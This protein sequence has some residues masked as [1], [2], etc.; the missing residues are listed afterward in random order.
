MCAAHGKGSQATQT[1]PHRQH[2]HSSWLSGEEKC[3]RLFSLSAVHEFLRLSPPGFLPEP[4]STA[5]SSLEKKNVRDFLLSPSFM[6][7]C[8]FL[9]QAVSLFRQWFSLLVAMYRRRRCAQSPLFLL[10]N[11][12][13][14]YSP[15]SG[16]ATVCWQNHVEWKVW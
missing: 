4:L 5:L 3:K 1:S 12:P 15:F 11:S 10:Q 9:L 14:P 13:C 8:G 6:S 2:H 16:G 7:S